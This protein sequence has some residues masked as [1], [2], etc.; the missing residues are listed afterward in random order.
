MVSW[1]WTTNKLKKLGPNKALCLVC[2]KEVAMGGGSTTTAAKHL[3]GHGIKKSNS[4]RYSF[5]SG[6]LLAKNYDQARLIMAASK[7]N[8][9]S[10]QNFRGCR[11]NYRCFIIF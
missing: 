3:E 1:I 11:Q 6:A 8:K 5:F 9:Y 7:I 4:K 10:R 2:N